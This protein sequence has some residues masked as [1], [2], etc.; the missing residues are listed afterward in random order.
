MDYIINPAIFYWMSVAAGLKGVCAALTMILGVALAI[1]LPFYL[2][3]GENISAQSA[4]LFRIGVFLLIAS[5]TGL[6]FIPSDDVITQM[7]VANFATYDMADNV[8][9]SVKNTAEYILGAVKE[10]KG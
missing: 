2:A 7:L 8:I 9:E 1:C 3:E 4:R 10:V 5:A 6:V